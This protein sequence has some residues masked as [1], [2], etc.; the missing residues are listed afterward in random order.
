ME[1]GERLEETAVREA[2]EETGLELAMEDLK[3][4]AVFS[5]PELF[6][7]YPNGDQ[8]YNVS[9]VYQCSQYQGQL[10]HKA[11]PDGETLALRFFAP[12][13]INLEQVSPPVQPMLRKWLEER[14]F[15]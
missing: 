10:N 5:G 6:Y 15:H 9:V 1:P 3:L 12:Q 14:G 13:D 2:R 8:V 11:L 4:F 7:T